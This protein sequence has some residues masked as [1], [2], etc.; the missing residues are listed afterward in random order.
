MIFDL[1]VPLHKVMAYQVYI[2]MFNFLL[3]IHFF[4]NLSVEYIV[5]PYTHCVLVTNCKFC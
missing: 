3:I 2:T 5:T 1:L 4:E